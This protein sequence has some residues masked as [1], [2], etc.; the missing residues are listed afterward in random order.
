MKKKFNMPAAAGPQRRSC[1]GPAG[2]LRVNSAAGCGG[3]AA[4]SAGVP[5]GVSDRSYPRRAAGRG[6]AAAEA[7][8]HPTQV[9]SR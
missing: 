3:G 7:A 5:A 2:V 4:A 1:G 8:P 9:S 6:G